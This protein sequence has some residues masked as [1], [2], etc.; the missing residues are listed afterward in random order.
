LK[1][2]N[3]R[4]KVIIAVF[5]LTAVVLIAKS[6]QIQIFDSSF[7]DKARRAT[8]EKEDQFPSRG[9][10][11][12][13]NGK[14]LVVNEPVYDMLVTFNRIDPSMDTLFFCKLLNIT[15][16]QFIQNTNKN[17]SDQRFHK[18]IPFTFLSK[19]DPLSHAMYAE[20][21]QEFPGF[22]TVKRIIRNYP[23]KN[24]AHVLGY[25]GEVNDKEIKNDKERYSLGD[26]IGKSGVEKVY[27][28]E[29]RGVKGVST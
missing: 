10:I 25:L 2:N 13:R 6:A 4:Q 15:K 23:Q 8:L 5:L 1:Q 14:L 27:E 20:H 22:K 12:D 9:L 29:L 19:I 7:A 11:Y 17:W 16:E 18:S 21:Q 3:N 28:D 24:G 26:Y